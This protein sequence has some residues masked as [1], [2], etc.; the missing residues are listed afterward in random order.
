TQDYYAPLANRLGVGHLK[1]QLE[2]WAFRYLNPTEYQALAKAVNLRKKERDKIIH[3]MIDELK[4]LLTKEGLHD[5]KISGRAKHLYSI[6]RQLERKQIGFDHIYD[7]S[8]VRIL[9]P[10]ITDCYTALSIVHAHWTP[11]TSEFDD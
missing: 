2:D 7:A 10:T 8:A 3:T 11:I 5:I 4:K 6:H 1:W 9:V